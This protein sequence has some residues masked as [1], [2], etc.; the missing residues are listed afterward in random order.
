MK[1]LFSRNPIFGPVGAKMW[2]HIGPK[3]AKKAIFIIATSLPTQFFLK[4][5]LLTA[6]VS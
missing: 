1:I 3:M 4:S 5:K 6:I 2:V